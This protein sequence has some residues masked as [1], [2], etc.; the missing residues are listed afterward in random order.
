[1][2]GN[3]SLSFSDSKGVDIHLLRVCSS[4]KIRQEVTVQLKSL[5]SLK[6]GTNAEFGK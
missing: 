2:K 1:M 3:S 6:L 5:V 4:K